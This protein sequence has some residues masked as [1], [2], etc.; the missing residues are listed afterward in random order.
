MC[1]FSHFVILYS[2][3]HI[4]ETQ[5][6]LCQLYRIKIVTYQIRHVFLLLRLNKLR[7]K[8]FIL[9]KAILRQSQTKSNF[10]FNLRIIWVV[11]TTRKNDKQCTKSMQ[12]TK[13]WYYKMTKI[14]QTFKIGI[15]NQFWIELDLVFSLQ[16]IGN[17]TLF[18]RTENLAWC[19]W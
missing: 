3:T 2:S 10:F 1:L 8:R 18:Y 4:I 15:I 16:R 11:N 5:L 17:K 14:I 19:Q 6:S 13:H 12:H 9:S 7:G